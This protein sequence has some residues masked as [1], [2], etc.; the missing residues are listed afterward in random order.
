[1]APTPDPTGPSRPLGSP[2]IPQ[3][4]LPGDRPKIG[5]YAPRVYGAARIQFADRKRGIEERRRVAFL[6]T[7][8]PTGRTLDWDS[9]RPSEVM[10]EH[11]LKEPPARATY[12]ALPGAAML[13]TTFTRW[14]KAFDRWVARTQR[15]ELTT[16]QDPPEA[17]T[18]GPK[19]G[20]VSVELVAIVWELVEGPPAA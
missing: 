4:Y 2:D 5:A 1:V 15:V 12:L 9:A 6:V 3:F 11:L 20:G 7:I 13:V 17:V 16:K 10:P 14:A 18:I 8:S 19:R